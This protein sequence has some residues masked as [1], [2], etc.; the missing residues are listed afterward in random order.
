MVKL[1]TPSAGTPVPLSR[2]PATAY[3]AP[4]HKAVVTG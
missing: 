2:N 4:G 3:L 1:G